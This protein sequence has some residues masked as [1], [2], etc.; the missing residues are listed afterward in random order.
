MAA[1]D[2]YGSDLECVACGTVGR[3]ECSEND[4]AFMRSVDFR[5]DSLDGPFSASKV[6]KTAVETEIVCASCGAVVW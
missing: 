4:Y 5:I 2:R 3:I 1:R 6:G